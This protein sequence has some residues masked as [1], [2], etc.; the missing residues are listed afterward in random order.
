VLDGRRSAQVEHVD[1]VSLQQVGQSISTM[2]SREDALILGDRNH[3]QPS[4]TE[5]VPLIGFIAN[6]GAG[7]RSFGDWRTSHGLENRYV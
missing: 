2:L 5:I 1:L 3:H 7:L 6:I 4:H